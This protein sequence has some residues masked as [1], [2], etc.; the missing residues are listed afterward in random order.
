[1]L[2]VFLDIFLFL[3]NKG[4]YLLNLVVCDNWFFLIIW[5]V[6]VSINLIVKLV[7]VF[8]DVLGVFVIFIFFFWVYLIL[9]LLKLVL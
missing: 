7:V 3:K 5:C 9:I 8:V 4:V 6:I 1:M 2:I